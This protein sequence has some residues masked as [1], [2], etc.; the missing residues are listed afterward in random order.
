MNVA[1]LRSR[2]L[3]F[4]IER[5]HRQLPSAPL[6]PNDPTLLFTSAGMV[7][8]KDI[9][10]GRVKPAHR[11]VTTC[12]KCFRTTDIGNVGRTAYHN[13][14]FEMLGNFSFGDYFKQGAIELWWELLTEQLGVPAD[15]LTAAV[16][17][18]DDEAYAI[19]RD[20]IGLPIDRIVRL[21]KE[22]N[23]WGPVG[24]SGPCGPDSEIHF[25]A[26]A[27]YG[28]GPDCLGPAC[29]CN[30]FNELGNIV[31]IQYDQQE[32]GSLVPLEQP[33]IDTGMG[34]ER[35]SSILQGVSTVYE[36]DVF[37]P[38]VEAIEA[39]SP[40]SLEPE[41][42]QDRN[43][44]ADHIRAAVFLLAEQVMPS[45]ERQ[46]YVLRRI[47]R[48]AVQACDRIGIQPG[49][50]SSFVDPV[51]A[52]LGIVYPEIAAAQTLAEKA[53]AREERE[54][55]RVLRDGRP[56][57]EAVF[58]E[59]SEQGIAVVPGDVAFEW[60]DTYG[61]PIGTTGA[62]ADEHGLT[63]DM[64]GYWQALEEQRN[65]SKKANV[66]I[67]VRTELTLNPTVIRAW[68]RKETTFVGYTMSE[69]EAEVVG[70][71]SEEG[72]RRHIAFT[73]T[74]F[75]A[76]GGGQVGDT[77]MVE[78]LTRGGTVE[79]YDTIRHPKGATIHYIR[80]QDVVFRRG[81]RCRLAVDV[82]RRRRIER[83]HTATHLLHAALRNVLGAH[84]KQAGSLVNDEELRFDFSH[85]EKLSDEQI[86]RVEDFA[87]AAVLADHEVTTREVR[88]EEAQSENVIGLFEDEY[89]GK[90][91]VRVVRAGDVSAELC[92]G[93][94]VRR[95]GEIGLIRIV[96]EESIASGVRRI[97][98][99]TGD[100]V[101]RK[102]RDLDGLVR[103]V[104][105]AAGDDP[106]EGIAR[107]K[108]E[109]KDLATRLEEAGAAEAAG[110][111]EE[112]VEGAE[113]IGD[114]RLVGGRADLNGDQLKSLADLLEEKARPSAVVLVGDAD[115]S[116]L[117]ICKASKGVDVD[118]GGLVREMSGILG[119][120]GGGGRSFAQGG[121]PKVDQLDAARE[122]GVKRAREALT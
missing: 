49:T 120:G 116:G 1:Q 122:A 33:C 41:R 11:R 111:S 72:T 95:T 65:R 29:D 18:E 57:E 38:I 45:N 51:V 92:G 32:D 2:F 66:H 39:K 106:L 7:Q 78:N 80:P 97:R 70:V 115:G 69:T 56:R 82:A 91:L 21:G 15:R 26:G 47:L 81:D 44:I 96:S 113:H 40:S 98:A 30:R 77:G 112:L 3:E 71:E 104:R 53:V 12:Q 88:L 17:E 4:F 86:V 34:L 99:V 61:I 75:Y 19:W 107:L 121:G 103:R 63:I 105:D 110:L 6:V 23:W 85:F 24:D 22:H 5:D 50:L 62:W 9:F 42:N 108:A 20:V 52:S 118:C 73:S 68:H 83:N 109:I 28:C 54:V 10:A 64:D 74:P 100:G 13:T 37:R 25:D 48:E 94:H 114:V 87:N 101:L 76:E 43:R 55:R 46:G 60:Q 35:T 102:L 14:F 89:R 58:R 67:G 119:G 79:V 8:F 117:V 27:E 59:L 36:T 93:T 16:Y 84:V 31:F 90:D